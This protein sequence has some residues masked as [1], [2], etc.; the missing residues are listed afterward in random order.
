[1]EFDLGQFVNAALPTLGLL[2]PL[3]IALVE[4]LGKLG[5][6]GKAQLACSMG[7]G[8]VGGV[9]AMIAQLGVPA[10]FAGWFGNVIVGLMAGGAASGVYEAFKS[11]AAKANK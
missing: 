10:D 2:V 3:I 5:V 1:M 4:Y 11:A 7:F 8:L 6:A 9:G